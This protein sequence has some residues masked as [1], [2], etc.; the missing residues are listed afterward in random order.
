VK[1][2]ILRAKGQDRGTL[3]GWL[4]NKGEEALRGCE[5]LGAGLCVVVVVDA[6]RGKVGSIDIGRRWSERD[7]MAYGGF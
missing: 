7:E 2:N 3:A 4:G 1:L 5:G 6:E